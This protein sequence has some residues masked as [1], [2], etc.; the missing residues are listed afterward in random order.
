LLITAACDSTVYQFQYFQFNPKY[1]LKVVLIK[2][3]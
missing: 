3:L 1:F 2:R